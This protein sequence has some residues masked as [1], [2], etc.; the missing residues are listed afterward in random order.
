MLPFAC[1]TYYAKTDLQAVFISLMWIGSMMRHGMVSFGYAQLGARYLVVDCGFQIAS[2]MLLVMVSRCYAA[3]AKIQEV[4]V[5]AS[6]GML[7][8]LTLLLS[9]AGATSCKRWISLFTLAAHALHATLAYFH[10]CDRTSY[11]KAIFAA[12]IVG[13]L[14]LACEC[15]HV[16]MG[17]VAHLV[18]ILYVLYFWK[19]L[20]ML[21]V[22]RGEL[23]HPSDTPC[24][25]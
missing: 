10:V 20:D 1:L 3:N 17:A 24:T 23:S 22:K 11:F 12:A 15:G 25:R 13:A 18:G 9:T 5:Y 19:A 21:D 7:L 4:A 8:L 16:F 14:L 2:L 6:T